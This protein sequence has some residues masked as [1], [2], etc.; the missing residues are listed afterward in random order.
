MISLILLLI[1]TIVT[2]VGVCISVPWVIVVGAII[3]AVGLILFIIWAL[4][5]AASTPCSLM[6]TLHCIL[7]WLVA[8][9]VPVVAIL[10]LIFAGLP[11]AIAT[12][13]GGVAWG[14]IFAWMG[15]IMRSVR[16]IPTC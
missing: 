12:V 11:C 6:R 9:V 16:C 13:V 10:M 5:C 2:V 15:F 4:L 7:F 3:A 8:V 14:S 1:G